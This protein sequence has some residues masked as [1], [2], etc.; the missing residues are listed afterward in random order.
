MNVSGDELKNLNIHIGMEVYI[1]TEVNGRESQ[2]R[3][4]VKFIGQC[5]D[6]LWLT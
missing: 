6:L 3:G 1:F 5:H 4:T 2:E